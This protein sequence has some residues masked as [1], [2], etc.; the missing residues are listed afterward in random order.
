MSEFNNKNYQEIYQILRQNIL[1][2][3]GVA[4]IAKNKNDNL[5]IDINKSNLEWIVD[6]NINCFSYVNI[7]AVTR[8]VQNQAKYIIEKINNHKEPVEI[9]VNVFDLIEEDID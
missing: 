8:Q 5:K 4:S 1:S 6:I 3:P 7:W 9:N 2:V